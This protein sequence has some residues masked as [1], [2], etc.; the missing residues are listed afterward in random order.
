MAGTIKHSFQSTVPD[1]GVAGEVGPDEW[2]ASLKV[3]EGADGQAMVRRT[4]ATDGWELMNLGALTTFINATQAAN[5][6]TSETDLHSF[7]LAAAHLNVNKRAV[8]LKAYGSFAANANTKTLRL[9]FGAAGTVTLNPTTVAP[10]NKRFEVEV[11]LIRTASNIQKLAVRVLLEGIPME[12]LSYPGTTETDA[13]ALTLK[14]TGQSGT[15][16]SDILLDL[17]TIEFLN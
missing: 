12:L 5:V 7:I 17:T 8:R 9:K 4:S 11:T 10:N 14:L 2:N 1:E 13:N 15:G 6:G 16:S 3:A